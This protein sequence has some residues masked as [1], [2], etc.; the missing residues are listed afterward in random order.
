VPAL[1]RGAPEPAPRLGQHSEEVLAETLGLTSSAIGALIDAG[2]VHQY[3][4]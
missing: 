1:E 3:G 2:T 4:R